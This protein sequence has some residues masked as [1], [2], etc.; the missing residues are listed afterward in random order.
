MD[1]KRL[2]C[3]AL[4]VGWPVYFMFYFIT[5]SIPPESCHVVHC[6]LDDIIPFNE[7]FAIFYFGW[8][9]L[10]FGSL[11]YFFFYDSESFKKL[12][13][14]IMITQA[15]AIIIYFLYPSIQMGRPEIL[16]SNVFCDAMRFI[17][18]VDTPTGVFPS[19][20]VAYSIGIASVWIKRK[21][22]SDLWKWFVVCFSVMVCLSVV[23]VK[24]HSVLDVASGLMVSVVAEY[25]VYKEWYRA[26]SRLLRMKAKRI[27]LF[28]E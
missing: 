7:Y 28:A 9:A 5:E 1:R 3:L 22:T 27:R 2:D 19:L 20:H 10:L 15:I 11:C 23:F 13:I 6:A 26:L 16:G 18:A 17:Y 24:Q 8:Y 21:K 12:Q 25:I 4:L 14:F